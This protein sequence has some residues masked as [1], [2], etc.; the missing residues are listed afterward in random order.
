M[1]AGVVFDGDREFA[2]FLDI[3]VVEGSDKVDL[4]EFSPASSAD[5]CTIPPGKRDRKGRMFHFAPALVPRLHD[6][7]FRTSEPT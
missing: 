3:K 2:L 7:V 1:K 6:T 4:G 5:R